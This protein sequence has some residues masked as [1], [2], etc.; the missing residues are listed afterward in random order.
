MKSNSIERLPR[1][2]IIAA[3]TVCV[4]GAAHA[5]ASIAPAVPPQSP[6]PGDPVAAPPGGAPASAASASGNAPDGLDI[7]VTAQRRSERLSRVPISITAFNAATLARTGVSDARALTQITPG[8]NFQS[9]GS[10]AQPAIRGIG[11]TGSSVGDSSNVSLYIDGVYQPFQAAN[12]LTFVDVERIEVLKGPQGTLFGR[13]AAGGAISVTT[14]DPVFETT[15]RVHLS[16]ARFGDVEGGAY[17]S[18]PLVDDKLAFNLS[19]NYERSSGF[20]RDINLDRKSGYV[21]ALKLRGKLLFRA[22]DTVTAVVSGYFNRVNDLTTFGNQPLDGNAQVRSLL[23]NVLIARKKNT[24]AIEFLPVNRVRSYGGSLKLTADFDWATLTSLTAFAKNHQ[25]IYTDS[26]LT[27]VTFSHT[28]AYFNDDTLSQDLT[29]TS[30]GGNRF[31]WILGLSYYRE[32]GNYQARTRGGRLV[33]DPNA[34]LTFG[35]NVD[36]SDID[37]YAA[38][39]EGNYKITD[40]LTVI[41]GVRVNH[42][43]PSLTGNRIVPVTGAL[44]ARVESSDRFSSVTPRGSLRYDISSSVNVYASYSRGFKSGV[45]NANA[46]QATAVKPETVDAFEA[47]VKGSPSQSLSFDAAAY[48]YN[49]KNLQFS[50]FGASGL[51]TQLRNAARAEIY[52]FEANAT[53]VPLIGLNL[54]AGVAY[55]HGEYT[56]F[57]GAQGY[58]PTTNAQGVPI[59]G[60]TSYAFDASGQPL[61]R[62]PRFQANGTISYEWNVANG[63]TMSADLTGSRTGRLRYDLG[64]NTQQKPFQIFNANLVYTTADRHWRGT[65]FGTNIFNSLPIAGILISGIGTSVTYQRPATY[66]ARLEYLF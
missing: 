25:F 36:S 23:P 28:R 29:L 59:G 10:S 56:D 32:R 62:T 1:L 40:R 51:Q 61:I 43:R 18:T 14:L 5:Q 46:L 17:I 11:S 54:R 41:A 34:P 64:G 38:F 50:S 3:A 13:N 24:S 37:A 7:V 33:S 16:Y 63:A 53:V 26:D 55:T 66:G 39:A 27:P 21:R 42:D 57:I 65:L 19:A 8:L 47:G 48:H 4:P 12:Y 20:R 2:A 9:V 6:A 30:P 35:I 44:G 45:F 22:S 49:Y 15:G 58:R 31:N 52:G 60:N